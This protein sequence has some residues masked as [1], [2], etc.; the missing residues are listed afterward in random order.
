MD[1]RVLIAAPTSVRH[2]D[3][4]RNHWESVKSLPVDFFYLDTT[5]EGQKD[6]KFS[7]FMDELKAHD[8]VIVESMPFD[9]DKMSVHQWLAQARNHIREHF[10]AC[11]QYTHLWFIDT[12]IVLPS[13]KDDLSV[14]LEADKDQIGFPYPLYAEGDWHPPNVMRHGWLV[15]APD[16]ERNGNWDFYEWNELERMPCPAKVYASGMGCLL[17]KRS[18]LEKVPFRTHPILVVGED[19]WFHIEAAEKGFEAWCYHTI[20]PKHQNVSWKSVEKTRVDFPK[21]IMLVPKKVIANPKD[22]PEVML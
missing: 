8:N 10:L 4:I 1:N 19:I 2:R 11:Q 18:V 20:R 15:S 16:R 21:D 6:E 13:G 9:F 3:V 5:P 12:D 14:L 7:K 17:I 22:L